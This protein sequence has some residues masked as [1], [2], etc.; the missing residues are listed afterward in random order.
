M[1]P[2]VNDGAVLERTL[3]DLWA[4]GPAVLSVSVVPV[5]LTDLQQA[6]PG[7]RA[8]PRGMPG[9]DRASSRRWAARARAE[10]GITWAFGADE[11]YLRAGSAAAARRVRTTASTRWRTASGSVR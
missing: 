7:A 11:L 10:R 8:Q 2:G 4:F 6:P 9:R 1:S 5:G 3:S